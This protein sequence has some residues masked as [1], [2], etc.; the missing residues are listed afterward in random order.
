MNKGDIGRPNIRCRLVG[1]E[2]RTTPDDALYASTPPLEALRAIISRAATVNDLGQ[3]RE[4]MINDVSRAY[5]YAEAT[6]C[7]YIELPKEDPLYDPNMLGRLRLCLYG[8][9]DA[10]LNWQQT[11]SNHLVE[12]GFKRGIGHPSVF[13]HPKKDIWTLVHGDDYCSAGTAEAL[14]WM[15]DLLSKK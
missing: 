6:R 8:T 10:A 14:D 13:H 15:E 4:V 1:K 11:L 2:F 7:M 12:A 9:R 3:E 5:F